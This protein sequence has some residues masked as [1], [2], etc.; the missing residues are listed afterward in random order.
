MYQDLRELS[1]K[2]VVL[3]EEYALHRTECAKNKFKFDAVMASKINQFM[4][5]R[6]NVGMDSARLM[7]LSEGNEEV[8]E[9]D[10]KFHY[11]KAQYKGLDK[12]ID[13][14]KDKL[15]LERYFMKESV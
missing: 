8:V 11:H 12:I 3:S 7:L 10:R 13:A 4:E 1:D 2:L 15:Y 6:K 5:K 14:V 9:Y